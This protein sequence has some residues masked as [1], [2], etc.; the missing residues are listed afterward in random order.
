MKE[1][2][3]YLSLV[4]L[5]DFKYIDK[6][7]L[8]RKFFKKLNI[9][10]WSSSYYSR[11]VERIMKAL[12]PKLDF[13]RFFRGLGFKTCKVF[14]LAIG[15]AVLFLFYE[16]IAHADAVYYWTKTMGGT[17]EDYSQSVAVDGSGNIYVTGYFSGTADFDPGGGGDSHISAGNEDIFLTKI[18]ADGSYGWTRTMGGANADYGQSVAVDVSGNVYV[19]G[20]FWGVADFDPGGGGDSHMSAGNEDIFIT[21]INADGSYGWTR[22]MGG[23]NQDFGQSVAVDGSGNVYVT[24]YF[25]GTADFDFGA[26]IDNKT[27]VGN[28]DIFL[29][30][31]NVGGSYGWTRTMGGTNR[32]FGQSVAVD[33]SENVYI[34][35]YFSGTADFDPDA[36][37]ADNHT[38]AGNE[39]IFLTRIKS[40]GSYGWTKTMGGTNRDFGQS[41]AV[42]V[43]ENVYITGYFSGTAD[44]DPDAVTADNHTSAG[45]EDIFL[46]R[47]KSDGSYGW[48]KTMGG[49]NRDFGQSV[50]VDVSENV[51][52][53]G[54]FS[55][56]A[57]FD[58]DAVTADSHI[59]AGNEDIF[60]TKIKSDGSY[61]WT[62][63]MGGANADYGQSVAGDI[64]GNV[65]VTGYFWGVADFDPGGGGD[66]HISAGNEDIFLTKIKSDGSYGW[67]KTM[68]GTNA[69][70][71]Q[72]VAGDISVNFY[73]TGYFSGTADFDP[74]ATTNNHISVGLFDIFLT[75]FRMAGFDVRPTSVSTEEVGGTATFTVKLESEPSANVT[76]SVDS[77]DTT[78]GTVDKSSLIFTNLNWFVNQTVTIT[79][80]A[81]GFHS[82][83][84]ILGA[85]IST[86]IDYNGLDPA[87]VAVN[88]QTSTIGGSGGGGCF[89]ATA[90]YGSMVEP[91]VEI[92]RHFRDRFLLHNSMG[93]GFVRLYNTYSP[94]IADFIAEHDNLRTVVRIGLLPVVS[95]SWIALKIGPVSV[96]ALMLIFIFCFVG[97]VWFSRRY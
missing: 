2:G 12:I 61:G 60:L 69:D 52:I 1:V 79:A 31:I 6:I 86:D 49:T 82:Y 73:V 17:N 77:S 96:V 10:K 25:S 32:D 29:T 55:G 36:V 87:D 18:N 51:Y 26:G 85:A 84:I 70:Y 78:N 71:G 16:G 88:N 39:D 59:S 20:Y 91:H 7:F 67:T 45:N 63:T 54:Y 43:S 33:V 19:T 75:K 40:D 56:S 11:T 58:P 28:E 38:S 72:S 53:T 93:K 48:T 24:G 15:L 46:T 37:T 3:C 44:F 90:A 50:A 47:I 74:E 14:V 9:G 83:T 34:T 64:S 68:G 27:S 66:S 8:F 30:K 13:T 21:K 97:L 94:P 57:D 95:I 92:L 35:G 5:S 80:V 41:V 42:D 81:P 76:I 65:Y 22:T 89:I 62:K 4:F 23:T